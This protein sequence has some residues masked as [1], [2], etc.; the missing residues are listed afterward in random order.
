MEVGP[1]CAVWLVGLTQ[2]LSNPFAL[3]RCF[4]AP[5]TVSL[6]RQ[7]IKVLVSN[8][9][10]PWFTYLAVEYHKYDG[11]DGADEAE[12]D[13]FAE[14]AD[15]PLQPFNQQSGH[16][17]WMSRM[18]Y[19]HASHDVRKMRPHEYHRML[20]ASHRWHIYMN[21]YSPAKVSI[22]AAGTAHLV[23]EI[24]APL[25]ASVR[26]G[27]CMCD[28]FG[29]VIWAFDPAVALRGLFLIWAFD[30]KKTTSVKPHIPHRASRSCD[31]L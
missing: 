22:T 15:D 24:P 12:N 10:V 26:D 23:R 31:R 25:G 21:V 9:V 2:T 6:W 18:H 20:E 13:E 11:G 5:L 27:C 7:L 19:G 8:E 30:F 14:R 1:R 16:S 17:S 29:L 4:E 28:L 3:C